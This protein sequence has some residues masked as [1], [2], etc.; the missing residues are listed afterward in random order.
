[1]TDV[2]IDILAAPLMALFVGLMGWGSAR[3]INGGRALSPHQRG[4]L[5]YACWFTLGMGYAILLGPH[6]GSLVGWPPLW[7]PILVAWGA[8]L[9]YIVWRRY[10]RRAAGSTTVIDRSQRRAHLRQGFAVM[11][12]LISLILASIEWVLVVGKHGHLIAAILWT[13]GVVGSILLAQGNRRA[14]VIVTMRAYLVLVVIGAI[15]EEKAAGLIFAG[16][17]G[18]VYVALE[19]LWKRPEP[20]V[21]DL[22]ALAEESSRDPDNSNAQFKQH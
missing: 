12:F 15:A 16:V 21:L 1:M 9:A 4:T 19:K 10:R 5:F 7:I 8:L 11:A 17:A 18:A 20:P 14:T 13:V 2:L 22:N 3:S 6:L